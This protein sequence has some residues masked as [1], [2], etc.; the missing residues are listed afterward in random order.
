MDSTKP[1]NVPEVRFNGFRTPWVKKRLSDF[2]IP[3]LRGIPKPNSTY[4][5]L[6][7]RSHFKGLFAKPN[8]D[9]SKIAMDTLYVVK[10]GD[11]VVNITFAW[12]GA[13]AIATEKDEGGLV[14]HRFPTYV[15][16][17][18]VTSGKFFKYIFPTKR[19]K[20]K[21]V[22]ASPGG[23]GRNRVLNKKEFLEIEVILPE[24]EEQ[25]KIA[26]FLVL[27]D[28]KI[29]VCKE[30]LSLLKKYKNGSLH[31][32]FTQKSRFKNGLNDF[33]EWETKSLGEILKYEQPTKYIV[34]STNYSDENKTPVLTAGKGFVLGYT[35]ELEG[36]FPLKELPVII[37]DDF[38]TSSQFVD[39]TF[40][41]K[42]SAM[43]ILKPQDGV[44]A[45][46]A[47]EILNRIKFNAKEH[48]RYWIGE[49]QHFTISIPGSDEQK[50]IATFI[51]AIDEK[52]RV[53]EDKLDR[54]CKYRAALEQRMFA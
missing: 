16:D 14:S 5:A 12:E 29:D 28:E 37:F 45:K 36:I 47:Y 26:D 8:S 23:A 13:V 17:E 34:K 40:K 2:L 25:V 20:Y 6:G 24:P 52:I 1:S 32:I 11:L 30:K 53:E 42:S 43:K 44:N 27:I 33:P 3:D 18:R 50:A 4:T 10:E 41:V 51:D 7:V 22:A 9:P 54:L 46:L 48:K 35:N 39:F 15:F 19:F 38:T 49:F 21:L 31:E